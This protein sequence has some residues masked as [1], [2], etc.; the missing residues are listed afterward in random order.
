[1]SALA[2]GGSV[3]SHLRQNNARESKNVL[4]SWRAHGYTDPHA[5]AERID[6]GDV[7]DRD[8]P[9]VDDSF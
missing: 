1:M 9:F 8:T 5:P 7:L 4:L 2:R 3:R 6:G